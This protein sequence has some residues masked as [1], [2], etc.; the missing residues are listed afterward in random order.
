M[1][2]IHFH[3][4]IF[5]FS[6]SCVSNCSV[7]AAEEKSS[8]RDL[9]LPKWVY[10]TIPVVVAGGLLATVWA[11][12]SKLTTKKRASEVSKDASQ[13]SVYVLLHDK[14]WNVLIARKRMIYRTRRENVE[15][16]V[17]RFHHQGGQWV[18]IGGRR[19]KAILVI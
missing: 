7:E 19:F 8:K 3:L 6:F 12:R 9:S 18:L 17:F 4:S 13:K 14:R 16:H 15:D 1:N 2:L 11:Q 10:A 5:L